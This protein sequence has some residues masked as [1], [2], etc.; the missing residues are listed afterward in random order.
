MGVPAIDLKR[1]GP[2]SVC[3]MTTL[4]GKVSTGRQCICTSRWAQ[5]VQGLFEV[6]RTLTE[7]EATSGKEKNKKK[8]KPTFLSISGAYEVWIFRSFR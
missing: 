2:L 7:R 1:T 6:T 3:I 8:N 5:S 4:M